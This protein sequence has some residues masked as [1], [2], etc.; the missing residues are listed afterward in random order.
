MNAEKDGGVEGSGSGS[1]SKSR[2]VEH[3]MPAGTWH[4]GCQKR[5]DAPDFSR[6]FSDFGANINPS[7]GCIQQKTNV[8]VC[9]LSFFFFNVCN[10]TSKYT[11]LH[12]Y[13]QVLF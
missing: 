4:G 13:R 7:N 8:K 3:T 12:I 9:A 1:G 11:V 10:V 2:G 5:S 6:F